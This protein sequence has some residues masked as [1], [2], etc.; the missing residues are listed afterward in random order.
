LGQNVNEWMVKFHE[1]YRAF[2]DYDTKKSYNY[3]YNS[4]R[5]GAER[6]IFPDR[7]SDLINYGEPDKRRYLRSKIAWD[8]FQKYV[9]VVVNDYGFFEKKDIQ[10]DSFI[11][12]T[13]VVLIKDVKSEDGSNVRVSLTYGG[14]VFAAHFSVGDRA[15]GP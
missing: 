11:A 3:D 13:T 1:F 8:D 9:T 15:K 7:F 6:K 5:V 14:N 10:L 4:E 2:E 12:Q